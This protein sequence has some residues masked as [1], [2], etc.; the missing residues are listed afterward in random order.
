MSV[1]SQGRYIKLEVIGAKNV[2]VPSQR[3]PA[4]IHVSIIVDSTRRWKSTIGV[5]S[6]DESVAWG[7]TVTL[8]S[9]MSPKLSMEIRASFEL[10]RMLGNGEVVGKL[11][12]SWDALLDRGNGPFVDIS[13]PPVRGVCP[14]LTLRATVL[15]PNDNQDS[16]L[17]ESIGTECEIVRETDA[18]HERLASYVTSQTVSELS[19]AIYHFQSVLDQCPVG[20][21]DRAG[22]LTNL[23]WARLKGYIQYNFQ[24]IDSITSLFRE[25]LASRPQGHPDHPLSIY[26]LVD[27]LLWRFRKENFTTVYIHESAQ[28]CCKLLALCPEATYLHSIVAGKN[29]VDYVIGQCNELEAEGSDEG[30]HIR[31]VILELCPLGNK[32][33]PIALDILGWA[34]RLRFEQHGST[35]DLDESIQCHREAVSLCSEGDSERNEYL[36]NLATSLWNRFQHQGNYHDLNDAISLY[37]EVL[38]LCPVGHKCRDFPLDNLGVALS[39]RFKQRGDVSDINR[40]ISLHRQALTLCPPGNSNR[41]Y[42]LHNLAHALY[43]IHDK[44]GVSED[45]N[46]AIDLYRDSLQLMQHDHPYRSQALCN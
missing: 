6:S 39:T 42:R 4:G 22:A 9:G 13:F 35:D 3:I 17:L 14:C 46:E 26:H 44:L 25:A 41:D 8:S 28:L 5:L 30:I 37:E 19:D 27:V 11:E 2:Q 40:A 23:A 1:K 18:G 43:M 7:N 24:D 34:L 29:G 16:A 32:H 20:H 31:R 38:R 15:Q 21:P 33:R 12:T 10:D 45:I 36:N